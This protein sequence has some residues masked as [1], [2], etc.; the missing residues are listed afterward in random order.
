MKNKSQNL[1]Q[2]QQVFLPLQAS[3]IACKR[4]IGTNDTMAWNNEADGIAPH[5]TANGLCGHVLFGEKC[6]F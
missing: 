4:T 5:G 1:F 3:G 2:L 6:A